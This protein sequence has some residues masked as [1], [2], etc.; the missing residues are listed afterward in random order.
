[1]Q[2]TLQEEG[3]S[4]QLRKM[5]LGAIIIIAGLMLSHGPAIAEE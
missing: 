5:I 4:M 3:T 2:T 1:M